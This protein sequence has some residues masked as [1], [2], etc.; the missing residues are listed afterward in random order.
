VNRKKLVNL[1]TPL[2]YA[3]VASFVSESWDMDSQHA[4][5]LVEKQAQAFENDKDYL[6]EVRS[7]KRPI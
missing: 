7:K 5:Q 2:Y 6:I 4:E 1:V 3:R